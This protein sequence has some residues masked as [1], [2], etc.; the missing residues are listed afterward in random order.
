LFF[1]VIFFTVASVTIYCAPSI[2]AVAMRNDTVKKIE[3]AISR[4]LK[5]FV[6][7]VP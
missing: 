5:R 4:I 1:C 7:L 6:I 2:C 3:K